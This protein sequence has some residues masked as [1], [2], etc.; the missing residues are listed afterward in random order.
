[1]AALQDRI[2]ASS[3]LMTTSNVSWYQMN[4]SLYGSYETF[5]KYILQ[6]LSIEGVIEKFRMYNSYFINISRLCWYIFIWHTIFSY[7]VIVFTYTSDYGCHLSFQL[8][9]V[10]LFSLYRSYY[11]GSGTGYYSNLIIIYYLYCLLD[12]LLTLTLQFN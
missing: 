2:I 5:V 7:I 12:Y 1:M 10:F 6:S 3:S 8:S 11:C 9:I 4:T